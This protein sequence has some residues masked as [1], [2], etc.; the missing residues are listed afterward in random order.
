MPSGESWWDLCGAVESMLAPAAEE[1][2]QR[3]TERV[4]DLRDEG[5][6]VFV[7]V[8]CIG[9]NV[10]PDRFLGTDTLC[11]DVGL[12]VTIRVVERDALDRLLGDRT[13]RTVDQD[14]FGQYVVYEDDY[15]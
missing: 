14:P 10:R 13:V 9:G 5:Y 3:L 6:R 15:D 12:R 11:L 4:E 7:R 2:Y 1:L 8:H